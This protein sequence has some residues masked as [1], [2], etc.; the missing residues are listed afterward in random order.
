MKRIAGALAVVALSAA[1][2]P[3]HAAPADL[4]LYNGKVLTVDKR[5][6]VRS[7]VAV[8][9]GKIVAVGGR[10]LLRRY[11]N[12]RRIDL[13]RRT[14]MPGFIDTHLHVLALSHRAIEPARARSIAEIQEMIALKAAE[15]GPGE[16]IEGL[17]WDEALLAEKRAPTRADLDAAAPRNPVVLRRAGGHSAVANSL[18]LSLAAIDAR[19]PDPKGGLIE[20]RRDGAPNGVIRERVD[21]VTRLVPPDTDEQ[22]RAS[23]VHTLRRLL[24]LG[25]TTVMEALTTIDDEPIGK[26]GRGPGDTPTLFAEGRP[27]WAQFRA[28]YA[29]EGAEL[30]RMICYIGWPGAERLRAFSRHTGFG[31][32][33]LKLGPIGETPYDGGFSGP[34]A[35]TKQDYKGLPGF[36]GTAFQTPDEAREMVETS[37]ALGWQ[38]GI[39]AIG[40]KAIETVAATYDAALKRRPKADRRWFLAHFTMMP[41]PETMK[42]MA[43]DGVW[44]SAQPNFLYSLEGRYE[45]TLD[46]DRLQHVNPVATPLRY[47]VRMAFGS[48][49]LPIGP[50][51][52]LYAATTRAGRDGR[53][54][55]RGEALTRQAAIRLYTEKAAYLAWD[56]EKKGTL[57][58]G[59]FADMIVLDKDP[60][61]VSD[62]ELLTIKVDMTIVAGRIVYTRE[63]A[64]D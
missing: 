22:M 47:G 20:R 3:L 4:V 30:P 27:T 61:T 13:K 9:E 18:A 21:L 6:S 10:E 52:G 36:R 39:H 1:A 56:E 57:A 23:Y 5:F 63:R 12:A 7:A 46:G 59:K 24:S 38:L 53:V 40:D 60:L 62:L 42:L 33:R 54:F 64:L 8:R 37:A 29:A 26:G 16:W 11:P 32:D 45:E 19:T 44:A 49:N 35:L 58:P 25:I 14:L 51:V 34:T 28:I 2:Q 48:D 15:L 50:M 17:G 41:S 31:D 55:G 43:A